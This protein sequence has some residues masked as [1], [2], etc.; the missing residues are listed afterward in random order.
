MVPR[1]RPVVVVLPIGPLVVVIGIHLLLTA[2]GDGGDLDAWAFKGL[3]WLTTAARRRL[4]A[5]AGVLLIA[6]VEH[7]VRLESWRGGDDLR[8]RLHAMA[9]DA[10]GLVDHRLW[11]A[12]VEDVE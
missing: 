3:G 6:G 5:L 12:H 1:H 10:D 8:V 11:L 4:V 7:F 2:R 9:R